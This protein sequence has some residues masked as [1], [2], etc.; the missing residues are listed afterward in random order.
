[1]TSPCRI[2]N[3]P[4]GCAVQCRHAAEMLVSSSGL[5][6]PPSRACFVI[7]EVRMRSAQSR[8]TS[9]AAREWRSTRRMRWGRPRW[10]RRRA[11]TRAGDGRRQARRRCFWR[12]RGRLPASGRAGVGRVPG[13]RRLVRVARRDDPAGTADP[14]HFPQPGDGITE[15]LEHLVGVHDVEGVAGCVEGVDVA[16]REGD[17][18]AAGLGDQHTGVVERAGARSIPRTRPGATRAPISR[19]MVPGPHP[20]SRTSVPGRRCPAR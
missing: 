7:D 6:W 12:C 18:A 4:S 20:T 3:Q 2:A 5:V 11:P 13:H 8:P 16:D 15:V 1:M 17:I 14:Q 9:S 10:R 19:V